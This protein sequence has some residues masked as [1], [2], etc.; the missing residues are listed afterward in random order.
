MSEAIANF[1]KRWHDRAA[2]YADCEH[3]LRKLTWAIEVGDE[4]EIDRWWNV[5]KDY[6]QGSRDSLH[7]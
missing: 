7:R 2:K 1:N 5:A 6:L 4:S 3:I